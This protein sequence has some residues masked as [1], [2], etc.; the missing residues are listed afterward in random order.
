MGMKKIPNLNKPIPFQLI[1]LT[2]AHSP[3]RDD[4]AGHAEDQQNRTGADGHQRLHHEA[5]IKADFVERP[6][7]AGRSV[8]EELAVEQHHPADQVEAQEHRHG[9]EDVHVSVGSGRR[10]AAGQASGPAEDALTRDR[11]DGTDE[12][13]QK[14]KENPLK[15]HSYPPVVCTVVHHKELQERRENFHQ[16]SHGAALILRYA[17]VL[18]Q[19]CV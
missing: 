18:N 10:V 11:M 19:R 9:E 4:P 12:E 16:F 2:D 17:L 8:G 6:D 3:C 14:D 5:S 1:P 13:L 7:A 15:G